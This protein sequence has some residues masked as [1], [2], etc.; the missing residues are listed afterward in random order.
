MLMFL[1]ERSVAIN[2]LPVLDNFSTMSSAVKW[3]SSDEGGVGGC[4]NADS[5]TGDG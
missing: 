1:A 5:V 4:L 3:P 2:V